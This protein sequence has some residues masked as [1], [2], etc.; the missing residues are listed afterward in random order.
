MKSM[1]RLTA[2]LLVLCMILSALGCGP[3]GT[4][5]STENSEYAVAMITD[6]GD[7]TDQ[8]FN[9]TTYESCLAYCTENDIPFT[10]QIP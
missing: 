6:S 4:Q 2:L 1:K 5:V 8:S 9:Q 7:I 10:L 3:S